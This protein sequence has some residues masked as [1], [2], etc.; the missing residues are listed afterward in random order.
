MQHQLSERER[1]VAEWD[2]VDW[3]NF[4]GALSGAFMLLYKQLQEE[5]KS[6]NE[7]LTIID[8]VAERLGT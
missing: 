8:K 5:G 4:R 2:E 1:A 7:A 6:H 3:G